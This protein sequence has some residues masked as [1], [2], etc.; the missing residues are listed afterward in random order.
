MNINSQFFTLKNRAIRTVLATS[1]FRTKGAAPNLV[2][3]AGKRFDKF[4][5]IRQNAIFKIP[6]VLALRPHAG[7]GQVGASE[8]SRAS[9]DDH[10]FEM[11][12]RTQHAFQPFPQLRKPVKILPKN[13]SGFLGMNQPYFHTPRQQLRQN[14]QKRHHLPSRPTLLH[15]HVL[16]VGGGN[17]QPLPSLR[18]QITNH[19]LINLPATD[20]LGHGEVAIASCSNFIT[21]NTST[22]ICFTKSTNSISFVTIAR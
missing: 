9:V 7:A 6:L 17:P 4:R 13:G 1:A 16:N 19:R 3:L 10:A 18:N 11:N 21:S 20:E 12:A 15:I 14:L 5:R 2:K 22:S 8:E